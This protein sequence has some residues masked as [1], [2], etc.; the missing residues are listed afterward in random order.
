[1]VTDPL[2]NP[3][4]IMPLPPFTPRSDWQLPDLRELPSW[5]D[6]K[7]VCIDMETR[8]PNLTTMGPGVRRDGKIVGFG[9][10]IEDGPGGY[11]PI[12][13]GNG[14]NLDPE[15]VLQY[16]KDQAKHFKG[17]IVGAN[18]P[19]DLDYMAEEKIIFKG[20]A[21]FRD[22]CVA[23]PIL[24]ELQF[25]YSL[26]NIAARRGIPG[27]DE[28]MLREAAAAYGVDPKA[29]LWELPPE[30][31][32]RYGEQDCRA[33]LAILRRQERDIDEQD[34]WDVWNL[35]SKLLPV[36]LK[37]R[38]RGVRIDFDKL[39]QVERWAEEREVSALAKL[40]YLTGIHLDRSDTT[41]TAALIPVLE[42]IGV[43]FK[44][45]KNRTDPSTKFPEGQPSITNDSLDAMDSSPVI[46]ALR[47]AKKFNKLSGTF[48]KSIRTHSVKGRIH[49]TFKQMIGEDDSGNEGGARYGRLS[50]S[51]PNLQQQPARDKEIGP[52]WRQIY[53]PDEGGEWACLDFSQQEPRWLVHYAEGQKLPKAK[54]MADRYRTDP[55]A[56]NHDMMATLIN[57][58]WP[59]IKDLKRKKYERGV[60]KQIFL[61]LCYGMGPAKLAKSL[62]LPTKKRSFMKNGRK[63]EYLGAGDEAQALLDKF[64]K[65][66]PFVKELMNRVQK[67]A[68]KKGYIFTAEG[69]RCRFP[70]LAKA[71][72]KGELYDWVFKGGNR[73]IQGS[74]G[75]QTKTAM[76][77]ADAAGVRVQL[78]VHDELDFTIWNPQE[79][80]DCAEIMRNAL[81]CSVPHKVDIET[82]DNWGEIS[83]PEWAR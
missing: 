67:K 25:S 83:E 32:G 15:H 7:R 63:I 70:K 21:Y 54:E 66:V 50:C 76:V 81:P 22:V 34:L 55:T 51:N 28:R 68:G 4:R 73:L 60:A 74:A 77:L 58:D 42:H 23:E 5:R 65:G 27:K 82:G 71:N 30:F 8:D 18:L 20:A 53:I 75:G 49:C 59:N 41:K 36:L 29:G 11:L 47:E 19:Y 9:F 40:T 14:R 62:G 37:M 12:A 31:V 10:A 46:D 38:R 3:Q 48:V 35:E 33:P 26:D 61:G 72:S 64:R 39:E 57:P 44:D 17:E 79:A 52:M 6:A 45:P 13:H 78:Q 43:D 2:R 24:D 69:R 56:D 1:M 16:F 80:L